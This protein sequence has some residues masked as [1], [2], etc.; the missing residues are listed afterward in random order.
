MNNA[1]RL[2]FTKEE[3]IDSGLPKKRK[4]I[5]HPYA[6][7][8]AG[9]L[10]DAIMNLSTDAVSNAIDKGLSES[11]RDN[12]GI[13]SAR[14]VQR[15]AQTGGRLLLNGGRRKRI[16]DTSSVTDAGTVR[17]IPGVSNPRFRQLQKQAIKKQYA[18][19]RRAK[20]T[21]R[22][23]QQTTKN[24]RKAAQKTA[25]ETRTIAWFLWRYRKS[26]IVVGVF[27]VLVCFIMATLSTESILVAGAG[28]AAGGA[29]FPCTDEDMLGAEKAYAAM[30]ADLQRKL[31]N[32]ESTHDYDEYR[33]DL[34]EIQHDP[35]VLIALLTAYH[36]GPWTLD[37]V[38]GTLQM[39]FD[40]QYVL[41]ESVITE[42]GNPD[43]EN[44][45]AYQ[46]CTVALENFNLSHL[47][48]Y[49]MGESQISMYAMYMA[50]LGNRPDLF[51]RSQ[52]PHASILEGHLDYDIP[53]EA[54]E[55]PRFAQMIREAE[56]YLGFPYVWGG[57]CPATSFDCSG[58]VSWIINHSG[59]NVGRLGAT[60]LYNLCTPVSSQDA[61]PGDLV[62][63]QGTYE[64]DGMSH[65]GLY[66]GNGMMI[67]CGTPITYADLR[68]A[69]WQ[70]YFYGF[71]RLPE[72]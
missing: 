56:K 16:R 51:P 11:D 12:A 37:E 24:A 28:A 68:T 33:Y 42:A 20:Q 27:A 61:R 57:Y 2:R 18:A 45:E 63:F 36:Q 17:S 9:K 4:Q 10:S 21:S 35:Y 54:L 30:E 58:Y 19:A 50:T 43:A 25:K 64:T 69:Y 40:M 15:T 5:G 34:D 67:H 53:E 1:S 8:A 3:A 60:G 29:T 7:Q 39:F 46:I 13:D 70:T 48:I 66:V 59:W 38:Q 44:P 31:D 32:Y 55:D 26:A 71:G 52:Y 49:I 23:I 41:R 72:P 47:P 65:V 14:A 22:T 62:F 6:P